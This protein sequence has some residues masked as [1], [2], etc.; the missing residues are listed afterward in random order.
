M[1]FKAEMGLVNY[2]WK[3]VN[4]TDKDFFMGV[5]GKLEF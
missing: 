3:M 4:G 5:D 1:L 2:V